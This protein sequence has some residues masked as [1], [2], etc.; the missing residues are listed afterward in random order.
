MAQSE[1]TA[2]YSVIIPPL[3]AGA[4]NPGTKYAP[5]FPKTNFQPSSNLLCY[6]R[7]LDYPRRHVELLLFPIATKLL[8]ISKPSHRPIFD[9]Q[10]LCGITQ[11]HR[12]ILQSPY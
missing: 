6:N 2:N 5:N 10:Y 12:R 11:S 1:R 9:Q 7:N 4:Q 8:L 3:L